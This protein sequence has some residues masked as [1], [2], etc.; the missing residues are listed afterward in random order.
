MT[1]NYDN[2]DSPFHRATESPVDRLIQT[3]KTRYCD[4]LLPKLEQLDGISIIEM[5]HPMMSCYISVTFT[6]KDYTF[7][8]NYE[9]DKKQFMIPCI[10]LLYG[11]STSSGYIFSNDAMSSKLIT[12][13][14]KFYEVSQLLG[15]GTRYGNDWNN[16]ENAN[17]MARNEFER[18]RFELIE[19]DRK[20]REE[21]KN[22]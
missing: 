19:S 8:I 16:F 13:F 5:C 10:S 12:V 11:I 22:S 1:S 7:R 14:E 2:Y 6:F 15:L 20:Q 18:L 4:A 3:V 17:Q 9:M 21:K